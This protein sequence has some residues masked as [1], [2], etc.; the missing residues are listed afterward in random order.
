MALLRNLFRGMDVEVFC[1]FGEV[2]VA[3]ALLQNT[4]QTWKMNNGMTILIRPTD[5]AKEVTEE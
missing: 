4:K 1:H 3:L 5:P 2:V